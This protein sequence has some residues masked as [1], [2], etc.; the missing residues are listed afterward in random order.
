MKKLTEQQIELFLN[1][2]LFAPFHLEDKGFQTAL[3]EKKQNMYIGEQVFVIV[4]NI[5][6]NSCTYSITSEPSEDINKLCE[7]IGD[8]NDKADAEERLYFDLI[9]FDKLLEFIK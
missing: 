9:S 5:T 6:N 8:E 2:E 3:R 4:D 1:G 7:G